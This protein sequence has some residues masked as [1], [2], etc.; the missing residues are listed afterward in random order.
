MIF[1]TWL[2]VLVLQGDG[3]EKWEKWPLEVFLR[4]GFLE[5]FS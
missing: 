3:Q 2:K 1:G 4:S 5:V